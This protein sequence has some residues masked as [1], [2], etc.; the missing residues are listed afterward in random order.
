MDRIGRE[1]GDV[2]QNSEAI[3]P[4]GLPEISVL[5]IRSRPFTLK[6]AIRNAMIGATLVAV[7]FYVMHLLA[8]SY[9]QSLGKMLLG[10][11]I[12]SLLF[13]VVFSVLQESCFEDV[14][15]TVTI[16]V[17]GFLF[18]FSIDSFPFPLYLIPGCGALV[19]SIVNGTIQQT[20]GEYF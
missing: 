20:L 13:A 16:F 18:S 6:Y 4:S 10:I 15:K 11:G 2:E 1:H 5:C 14:V 17:I 12:F 8:V 19:G 3:S 9:G 7:I